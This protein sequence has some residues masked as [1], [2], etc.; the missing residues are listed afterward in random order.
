MPR[1]IEYIGESIVVLSI[2]FIVLEIAEFQCDLLN[3]R[4]E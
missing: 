2:P 3:T 4:L 1:I